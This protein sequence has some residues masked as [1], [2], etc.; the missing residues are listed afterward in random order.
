MQRGLLTFEY[1]KTLL[2]AHNSKHLG[3]A[4]RARSCHRPALNPAFSF[5]RDFHGAFHF[6]LVLTFNTVSYY[7]LWLIFV[8]WHIKYI[9]LII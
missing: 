7:W 4:I 6:F 9:Y 2:L 5:H 8:F 3:A 1:S